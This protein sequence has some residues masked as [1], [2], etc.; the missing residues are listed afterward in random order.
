MAIEDI[1]NTLRNLPV[2]FASIEAVLTVLEWDYPGRQA[3]M[4][5]SSSSL[6]CACP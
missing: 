5:L 4:D 2:W 6:L 1:A 3:P